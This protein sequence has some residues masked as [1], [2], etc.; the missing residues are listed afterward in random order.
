M[1]SQTEPAPKPVAE[2]SVLSKFTQF[3]REKAWPAL[4]PWVVWGWLN[5]R[6]WVSFFAT[7]DFRKRQVKYP[8]RDFKHEDQWLV[9]LP[10]QCLYCAKLEGLTEHTW[11]CEL[12]TFES[13]AAILAFAAGL[14]AFF[15]TLAVFWSFWS[16]ILM[17][18]LSL[19]GG[20]VLIRLKSWTEPVSITASVC[21]EHEATA[22]MPETVL[23]EDAVHVVVPARKVAEVA[24]Q[25]IF[26]RAKSRESYTPSKSEAS[27]EPSRTAPPT[28]NPMAANEPVPG[29]PSSPVAT[30][31]ASP[32]QRV[33]P[34]VY[35]RPEL[36]PIKLDE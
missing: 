25:E 31:P 10:K 21:P 29:S 8:E 4:E 17:A 30:S 7:P 18:G 11:S 14:W 22:E 12:R 13:P 34:P 19:L 32:N 35:K 33:E 26:A 28:I 15:M 36:P 1:E 27:S 20:L 2:V 3:L 6:V 5:L 23:H 9:A 16:S 24:R